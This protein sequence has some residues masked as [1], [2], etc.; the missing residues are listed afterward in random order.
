MGYERCHNCKERYEG[1]QDRCPYYISMKLIDIEIKDAMEKDKRLYR[2][3]YERRITKE[4]A[5]SNKRNGKKGA[6]RRTRS[7][8]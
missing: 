1:C 4:E 3:E 5:T 6:S 8:M 2:L 7:R